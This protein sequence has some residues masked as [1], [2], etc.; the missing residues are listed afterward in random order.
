MLKQAKN[1]YINI[2]VYALMTQTIGALK[3]KL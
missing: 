3:I 1:E 2:H